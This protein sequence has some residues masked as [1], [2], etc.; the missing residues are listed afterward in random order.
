MLTRG[1]A[2]V[3]E[4]F[5]SNTDVYVDRYQDAYKVICQERIAI[6]EGVMGKAAEDFALLDVGCGAGIFIDML[7]SKY[8]KAQAWGMDSSLGMLKKNG[9]ISRKSLILGDARELPFR[10]KSFDL[11]NVDTV[12]HHLVDFRGYQNT[13]DAIERFLLSLQEL[14]KPEGVLIVHEIYHE[15]WLR[16]SLGTRMV[17][18]LSTLRLPPIAANLL[19]RVGLTTANAGVCFLTRRQWGDAF[20]QANYETL[21][22]TDKPWV[23]H[24]LRKI[25]FP[26]NGDLYYTLRSRES[27]TPRHEVGSGS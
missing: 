20:L 8:E 22:V 10:P 26:H 19:K 16:D 15:S 27:G 7:L 13:L 4:H 11:I 21:A 12:M 1:D 14:L 3:R 25:G 23:G 17:Y 5:D 24:R 6:L 2:L 9:F 18:E